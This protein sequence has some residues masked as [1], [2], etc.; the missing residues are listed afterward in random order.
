MS[1]VGNK[2]LSEI[3]KEKVER[4]S[5]SDQNN[6]VLKYKGDENWYF[7]VRE[8]GEKIPRGQEYQ[9]LEKAGAGN[10]EVVDFLLELMNKK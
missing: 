10:K 4:A 3:V 9:L 5:Y 8:T 6:L 2:K 7:V 1:I